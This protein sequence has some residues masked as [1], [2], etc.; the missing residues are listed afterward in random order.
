MVRL[1]AHCSI[2]AAGALIAEVLGR[3]YRYTG[4]GWVQVE[5][6]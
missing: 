3:V 2:D 1:N 5:K 4:P 6:P